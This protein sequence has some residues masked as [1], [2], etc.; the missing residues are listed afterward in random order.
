MPQPSGVGP[1]L[2]L[3]GAARSG[4]SLLAA[5]LGEFPQIDA[6]SVKE[7]NFFSREMQ[8]GSAWYDGLYA[9]RKAGLLRLDASA[10]Y[11]YPQY[12]QALGQ[13]NRA[14]PQSF[15]VYLV[16]DPLPRLV[17]HY[18][19]YRHYFNNEQHPDL[20]GALRDR[21]LYAGASDYSTWVP[22]LRETFG[23][24][25]LL[26]VPFQALTASTHA[27][28]VTVC[29]LLGISEP[30][31]LPQTAAGAQRYQNS[32]VEFRLD[33]ARRMTSAV[34][35][36]SVY[37]QLRSRLGPHQL[38]RIRSVLTRRPDLPSTAEVLAQ[39]TAEQRQE[40]HRLEVRARAAV[41]EFL[42]DQDRRLDL[43]W[44]PLWVF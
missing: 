16:R 23:E 38:R 14:A 10:S 18:L 43:Q 11:T 35:R 21:P 4:T 3:A 20:A 30:H 36:S 26:V 29:R 39:A 27:V 33:V 7:P 25:R 42:A 2:V 17:S 5:R 8:R 28:A 40:L 12:P 44:T 9:P 41:A 22:R 32:V 34:R 15:V 1:D 13:L 19:F 24:D 6:G 31:D 37:P